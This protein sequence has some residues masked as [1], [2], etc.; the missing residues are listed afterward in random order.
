MN[1]CSNM[2]W[3]SWVGGKM[4]LLSCVHQV[5]LYSVACTSLSQHMDCNRILVCI[6]CGMNLIGCWIVFNLFI[7]SIMCRCWKTS[8][9]YWVTCYKMIR[10]KLGRICHPSSLNFSEPNLLGNNHYGSLLLLL[11]LVWWENIEKV[12]DN[13]TQCF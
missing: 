7:F 3:W 8:R 11:C 12:L 13:G 4:N 5:W 10:C 2:G 9:S 1:Q 6:L